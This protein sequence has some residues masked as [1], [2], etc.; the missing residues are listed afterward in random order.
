MPSDTAQ[1][2]STTA[3]TPPPC[4]IW[5]RL[6]AILYDGLLL[7]AIWMIA[8]LIVVIIVNDAVFNIVFQLY[9]LIVS[10]AYFAVC[11]RGGQTLGMKAWRIRIEG[12]ES[13][14]SWPRTVTRF[15][16]A[17]ASWAPA[18][19]GYWWSLFNREKACWHDL[20]SNTRLVVEPP[21]QTSK[22]PASK[23]A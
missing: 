20:A 7:V 6:A 4:G 19:L 12:P 15:A 11:W 17:A 10:W 18:G 3:H 16:V 21:R 2:A 9:L 14:I 5:R 1:Q 13:P 8:A 22:R 23:G